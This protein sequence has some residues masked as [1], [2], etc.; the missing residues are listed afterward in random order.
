MKKH[1]RLTA[2][3]IATLTAFSLLVPTA[4]FASPQA[5]SPL[6]AATSSLEDSSAQ[7]LAKTLENVFTK[8]I[9]LD[10]SGI[11][12]VNQNELR[13]ILGPTEA[14]KIIEEI[15][16]SQPNTESLGTLQIAQRASGQSFVDC[17]V[18]KSVLGLIGGMTSGVYAE[19]IREKSSMNWLKKSCLDSLKLGLEEVSPALSVVSR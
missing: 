9:I 3:T 15:S 6:L 13:K 14:N 17:M 7:E 2:G 8:A 19:L 11:V 5:P 4:S 10:D 18:D 12:S 1:N 16:K